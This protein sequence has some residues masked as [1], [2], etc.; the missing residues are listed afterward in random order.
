MMEMLRGWKER[1]EN[2]VW[3]KK[4]SCADPGEGEGGVSVAKPT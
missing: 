4:S 1:V 2:E 3:G